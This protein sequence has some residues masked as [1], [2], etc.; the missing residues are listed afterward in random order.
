M[1]TKRIVRRS[2][3]KSARKSVRKN[4]KK[5]VRKSARRN[6]RKSVRKSTRKSRIY[7][8]GDAQDDQV[9]MALISAKQLANRLRNY[10]STPEQIA[11]AIRTLQKQ[12]EVVESGFLGN[13][14]HKFTF[15]QLLSEKYPVFWKYINISKTCPDPAMVCDRDLLAKQIDIGLDI[16]IDQDRKN[17]MAKFFKGK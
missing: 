7:R 12:Q 10:K 13:N 1:N 9:T 5:N 14:V 16:H 8:F 17:K 3:R 15:D 2:V 6:V 4:T 11:Q